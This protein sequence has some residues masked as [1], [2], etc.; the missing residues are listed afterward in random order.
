M[1]VFAPTQQQKFE[2]VRQTL[3]RLPL[4]KHKDIVLDACNKLFQ[5]YPYL[6]AESSPQPEG[7]IVKQLL[8]IRGSVPVKYQN[9]I[10]ECTIR[11]VIPSTFPDAP[12][13]I[14]FVNKDP[15]RYKVHSYYKQYAA[16][17]D[18]TITLYFNEA[19]SWAQHRDLLRVLKEIQ[20]YFSRVYPIFD[21]QAVKSTFVPMS[22]GTS[23]AM[24][25]G[26]YPSFM[27][28][29]MPTSP[30]NNVL[31]PKQ[32]ESKESKL[33]GAANKVFS[34]LTSLASTVQK[35]IYKTDKQKEAERIQK[36]QEDVAALTVTNLQKQ[37]SD[38]AYLINEQKINTNMLFDRSAKIL[39]QEQEI[40]RNTAKI[41]SAT[42][43]LMKDIQT[44]NPLVEKHDKMV[45]THENV[46]EIIIAN[47]PASKQVIDLVAE[48][49]AIY[50]V[51]YVLEDSFKNDKIT[52]DVYM[53]FV[54]EFAV[55]EFNNR[56]LCHKI[57]EV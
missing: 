53:K 50:D 46:D 10:F 29:V 34:A 22:T 17:D 49:K 27:P 57:L 9:S 33:E 44:L 12:P 39:F 3:S 54:R 21:S 52:Y 24:N 28:S 32:E 14:Q 30:K 25:T 4:Y 6:N 19:H 2:F 16:A 18:S 43:E 11:F 35:N 7:G 38:L 13:S 23:S 41:D 56:L 55:K 48:N 47:K 36:L 8:L 5:N 40:I 42:Q 1:S 45:L 15:N 51:L 37:K 31:P 26:A 20:E